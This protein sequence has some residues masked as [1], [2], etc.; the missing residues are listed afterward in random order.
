MN[1][2][3]IGKYRFRQ[4]N[5]K[6]R[7]PYWES[8]V[9][10]DGTWRAVVDAAGRENGQD[11]VHL[12]PYG[13]S[14]S[15]IDA[16]LQTGDFLAYVQE[17]MRIHS[18]TH[19]ATS[20]AAAVKNVLKGRATHAELGY[21]SS[22]GP[23]KQV[24]LWLCEGPI[25]PKD[26]LFHEHTTGDAISIY[27]VSLRDYG[28]GHARERLLKEEIKRWKEIVQPVFFPCQTMD[29]DPVDFATMDELRA[30]AQKL[31]SRSRFDSKPALS[32]KLNCVQWSTLV[33][34]LAVCFPLSKQMLEMSGLKAGYDANW[35]AQF[36]YAE[37]G[38]MGLNE[39]PIPFYT[40]QEIV[41]NTLDLYFPDKKEQ[42]ATIIKGLPVEQYLS[43]TGLLGGRRIMPNAFVI[44]NR[45]RE[46]GVP[47]KTKSV[48]EYI[49]TTVPAEELIKEVSHA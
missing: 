11:I 4:T 39:L 47:R 30:I 26:R 5:R 38:L 15:E 7:E 14:C 44:E 34:S 16:V 19:V 43:S 42:L 41:E 27:R 40:V 29:V 48:F 25:R 46:L 3:Y 35:S 8:R 10:C 1:I 36:G 32:F 49:G 45:L 18:P 2:S 33:F 9:W 37:E 31:V 6:H 28:V 22:E 17:P 21:L 13:E 23:A 24:S 12:I 20:Q